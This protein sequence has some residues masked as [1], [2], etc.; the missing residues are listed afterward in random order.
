MMLLGNS[1]S[2]WLTYFAKDLESG[3]YLYE[4]D[5]QCLIPEDQW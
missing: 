1:I 3:K 5:S 4:P 2:D